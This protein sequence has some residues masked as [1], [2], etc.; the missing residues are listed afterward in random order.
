MKMQEICFGQHWTHCWGQWITMVSRKKHRPSIASWL[1]CLKSGE[2]IIT[3]Q[4]GASHHVTSNKAAEVKNCGLISVCRLRIFLELR[5]TRKQNLL[6][7]CRRITSLWFIDWVTLSCHFPKNDVI[8]TKDSVLIDHT[9]TMPSENPSW[10]EIY[11][12]QKTN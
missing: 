12:T 6:S 3:M 1:V 9:L 2:L 11:N 10:I 7:A 5:Y 8:A 4:G